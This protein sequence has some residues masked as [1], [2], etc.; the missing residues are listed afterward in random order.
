MYTS[1]IFAYPYIRP[2]VSA[3]SPHAY[4]LR[5]L[6]CITTYPLINPSL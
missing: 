6:I 1:I 5:P 2:S 4:P 3:P